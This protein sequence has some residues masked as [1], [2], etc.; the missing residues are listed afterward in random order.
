MYSDQCVGIIRLRGRKGAAR[1]MQGGRA[2]PWRP[3]LPALVLTRDDELLPCVRAHTTPLPTVSRHPA[4]PHL[5][6]HQRGQRAQNSAGRPR[7]SRVSG[8]ICQLHPPSK[9]ARLKEA[10]RVHLA[11]CRIDSNLQPRGECRGQLL[12]LRHVRQRNRQVPA[13]VLLS[14]V[15]IHT[16]EIMSSRA[17]VQQR[18]RRFTPILGN[19]DLA[20]GSR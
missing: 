10:S 7:G 14:R 8:C 6:R 1:R 11:H 17:V 2:A 16:H 9:S 18:A 20:Y 13:A 15:P 19:N 12:P 5:Q 4:R 3:E